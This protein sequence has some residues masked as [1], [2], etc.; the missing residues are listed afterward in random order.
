MANEYL[1][2]K[3]VADKIGV[4]TNTVEKYVEEHEIH[5]DKEDGGYKYYGPQ[6]VEKI[7]EGCTCEKCGK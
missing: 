1:T 5:P 6:K 3:H 4:T 7:E 2:A